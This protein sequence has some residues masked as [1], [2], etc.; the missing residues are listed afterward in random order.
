M[1]QEEAER[2]PEEESK[3]N[4]SINDYPIQMSKYLILITIFF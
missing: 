1:L 3:V 4:I 2:K